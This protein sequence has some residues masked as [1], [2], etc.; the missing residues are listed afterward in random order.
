MH[1]QASIIFGKTRKPPL[2]LP[3]VQFRKY[4]WDPPMKIA[5]ACRSL[6][7]ERALAFFLKP[8]IVPLK[9]CDFVIADTKV[10][11]DHP[12]FLIGKDKSHLATPFSKTALLL[13]LEE[14]YACILGH[15]ESKEEIV[16]QETASE[17]DFSL[18]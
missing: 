15:S 10:V 17:K 1:L 9:Q 18:L 16:L 5:L 14:F 13:A 6:L 4:S 2:K 12:V 7:L 8:H 11:L 3:V